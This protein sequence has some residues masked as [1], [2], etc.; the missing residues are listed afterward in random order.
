MIPGL[1]F[2]VESVPKLGSGKA[3]FTEAKK[4]AKK[5]AQIEE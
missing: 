5:L 1:A 2:N 3:D 4:L